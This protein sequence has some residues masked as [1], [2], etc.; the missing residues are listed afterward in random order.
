MENIN[1]IYCRHG[2]TLVEAQGAELNF[3]MYKGYCSNCNDFTI[4]FI[5]IYRR[6]IQF[7]RQEIW[8]HID[9]RLS[10]PF[11][12]K[13]YINNL[14]MVIGGFDF[15]DFSN[16]LIKILYKHVLDYKLYIDN[17]HLL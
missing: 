3:Y 13:S 10:N 6:A 14:S 4:L 11:R 9:R 2:L 17:I 8:V 5:D 12:L 16:D 7:K 15:N 1:C